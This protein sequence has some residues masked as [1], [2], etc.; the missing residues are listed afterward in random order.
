MYSVSTAYKNA[1]RRLT[2]NLDMESYVS[3][4]ITLADDTIVTV[5]NDDIANLRNINQ[6]VS[7]DGF[8]IGHANTGEQELILYDDMT[9]YRA[10]KGAKIELKYYLKISPT[11]YEGVPLGIFTVEEATRPTA[12]TIK[13]VGYDNM[14]KFDVDYPLSIDDRYSM[15][16]PFE[17]LKDICIAL[18]VELWD[19]DANVQLELSN[20]PNG[21]QKH[22]L[23]WSPEIITARDYL[24][25]LCQ[26]LCGFATIDRLG[27]LR[28][29]CWRLKG[30]IT[31]YAIPDTLR[32]KSE[33]ND[34]VLKYSAVNMSVSFNEDADGEFVKNIIAP[35]V[36]TGAGEVLSMYTNAL[37]RGTLYNNAQT[38]LDNIASVITNTDP[39]NGTVMQ[40]LPCD[41]QYTGDPALDLGDWV[42]YTGYTAGDGIEV[43]IHKIDWKYRG[44]QRL[45]TLDMNRQA[46][47]VNNANRVKQAEQAQQMIAL[48]TVVEDN[49]TSTST[50]NALSANMGRELD[51]RVTE[52]AN[53]IPDE[54]FEERLLEILHSKGDWALDEN[55]MLP[56]QNANHL[57]DT[58]GEL[59][60]VGVKSVY[61][62]NQ[63]LK[64][65]TQKAD[66]PLGVSGSTIIGDGN[67]LYVFG[68]SLI[69]AYTAA[70]RY[71][72]LTGL[73]ETLPNTPFRFSFAGSVKVERYVYF[74]R[75]NF[76]AVG[77]E[78]KYIYRFNLDT[79]EYEKLPDAPEDFKGI[80]VVRLGG[81][82]YVSCSV[83]NLDGDTQTTSYG[84]FYKF[85]VDSAVWTKLPDFVD[86]STEYY[87]LFTYDGKINGVPPFRGDRS[88]VVFDPVEL[89]FEEAFVYPESGNKTFPAVC[90]LGG[91]AY[92]IFK[93]PDGS[94][95]F[96]LQYDFGTELS[97]D[98]Y[99]GE[100]SVKELWG[101]VLDVTSDIYSTT[102]TK[103]NQTWLDGKPIYRKLFEIP[104]ASLTAGL[105]QIALDVLNV[106]TITNLHATIEYTAST[107]LINVNS[108]WCSDL[109][110]T[111]SSQII[112]IECV[113]G[114]LEIRKQND[115]S[116][117]YKNLTITIEFTK[118]TD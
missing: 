33:F 79:F 104:N 86:K 98:R 101:Q 54:I 35:E 46:E 34:T 94:L 40:W 11:E 28:I 61:K 89:T 71:D 59:Y 18:G 114:N 117:A 13:L 70:Y 92:F 81:E 51:K 8:S 19:S 78:R 93:P 41:I 10:F 115:M 103:T 20:M 63:D 84:Q 106:E 53:A 56:V 6:C 12:T 73:S 57:V 55:A 16:T 14:T 82:I 15:R 66:L 7:K 95:D 45:E 29:V 68:G 105:T 62:Y 107:S 109:I 44:W 80:S 23:V 74:I 100:S 43:P 67:Y 97:N 91:I 110:P 42:T 90:V 76:Y 38:A 27:R 4:T 64:T 5:I 111:V 1:I 99:I 3:G 96:L 37:I 2:P 65:F 108:Y 75:P 31:G 24:D 58:D 22:V 47:R 50:D 118:T 26:L 17:R 72:V 52:V 87:R 25:Y 39:E 9:N 69:A 102:E 113:D 21:T 83:Q 85:N 49:L 88:G 116:T 48:K 36:P 77:A 32:K 60:I 30:T 112:K